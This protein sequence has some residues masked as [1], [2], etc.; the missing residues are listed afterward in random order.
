M[1]LASSIFSANCLFCKFS[2]GLL[3]SYGPPL[4]S[5]EFAFIFLPRSPVG[6][7]REDSSVMANSRT[8]ELLRHVI[9]AA[10]IGA[11]LGIALTKFGWLRSHS[12]F[13]RNFNPFDYNF[14]LNRIIP[15]VILWIIFSVYWTVASRNSAPSQSAESKISTAFHQIILNVALLLLFIPVPGLTGWFL[16]QRFHFLVAVGAIVQAAFFLLAISA[17]RHLGRNWSAEVRIGEGHELVRTGPY[18]LLRHPIYT[19]MLGMFLGTA[20]ASSQYHALLGIMVLFVAYL[21]KTRLEENIL[22]LTFG[23]DYDAYERE[24]WSLVPLLF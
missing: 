12:I 14:E 1:F 3:G 6:H 23:A 2:F 15:A 5:M 16:P 4:T 7:R 10:V 11:A 17:R 22:R 18:R 8:K 24:T 19:A 9:I 21:R 20:M 13:D